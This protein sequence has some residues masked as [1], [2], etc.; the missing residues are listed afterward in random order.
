MNISMSWSAGSPNQH[1]HDHAR[2]RT[3]GVVAAW[4]AGSGVDAVP[5]R[6][7]CFGGLVEGDRLQFRS[8]PGFGGWIQRWEINPRRRGVDRLEFR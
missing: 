5:E 2:H 7:C 8:Q 3:T 6:Q 1:R 4:S